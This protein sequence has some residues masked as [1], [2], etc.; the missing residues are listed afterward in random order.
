MADLMIEAIQVRVRSA[1]NPQ[2]YHNVTLLHHEGKHFQ[3]DTYECDC[4]GFV[5]NRTDEC[6]HIRAVRL[7]WWETFSYDAA[8]LERKVNETATK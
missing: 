4:K 7:A 3:Y 2:D 5:Y 1:S 6:R 8:V